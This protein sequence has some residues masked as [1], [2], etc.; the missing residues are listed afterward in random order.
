[1]I[2]AIFF[3][4]DGTLISYKTH[5]MSSALIRALNILRQKGIKLFISTGRP[6]MMVKFMDSNFTFDGYITLN[7][8][9]CFNNADVIYRKT[10]PK[11]DIVKLV[12]LIK[13]KEFPCTFI[14]ENE[15]Y[16]N[17]INESVKHHCAM[18]NQP[19]PQIKNIDRA[20]NNDIYQFLAYL[21]TEHEGVLLSELEFIETFRAV[22][23]CIDTIPK[24][25]GKSK[26]MDAL[27]KYYQI[28]RS[29]TMAFGDGMNDIEM[30]E[31]AAIGV[32]MGNANNNV[33]EHA[34]YV[35]GSVEDEGIIKALIHYG[36]LS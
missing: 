13:R 29:E 1:M 34:D 33:K 26:G 9:Y 3:D 16:I 18:T 24:G 27:L 7:G 31:F 23:M 30:L 12:D 6:K 21:D 17:F 8:Q 22:S 20:L 36:I 11:S 25:G 15:M 28:D 14:E 19:L 5:E 35:T 10:I 2:R 4:I 32:A